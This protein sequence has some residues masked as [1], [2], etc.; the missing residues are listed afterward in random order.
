MINRFRPKQR[1]EPRLA[2]S[3]A[4]HFYS[5]T[6]QTVATAQFKK[7]KT[8]ENNSLNVKV[9]SLKPR[10]DEDRFLGIADVS[11][12]LCRKNLPLCLAS[13]LAAGFFTHVPPS[14]AKGPSAG[15]PSAMG[16]HENGEGHEHYRSAHAFWDLYFPY[17]AGNYDSTYSYTPTS[18]QRAGAKL[19]A[20]SYLLAVHTRHKHAPSRRYIS[21]ETLRPTNQQLDDYTRKLP[22]A[23]HVD[24]AKLHCLMVFDTQTK[25]FVGS[26][27]YIVGSEPSAGEVAQFEGISAEFVGHQTL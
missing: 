11:A 27:C 24:P 14:H 5:Q 23:R 3:P 26:H 4:R 9:A 22:A 13:L 2:L 1:F 20:E 7:M 8:N 15:H 19:E 25:E 10:Q 17:H 6:T 21:V 16:T 12:R 18:E